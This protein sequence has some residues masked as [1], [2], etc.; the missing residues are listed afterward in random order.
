M[1][2]TR[3]VP[4]TARLALLG[5]LAVLSSCGTAPASYEGASDAGVTDAADSALDGATDAPDATED[6]GAV[7]AEPNDDAGPVPDSEPTP[8]AEPIPDAEPTPDTPTAPDVPES[9]AVDDTGGAD[10]PPWPE[11]EEACRSACET[12]EEGGMGGCPVGGS[13]GC[14]DW[15]LDVAPG[16]APDLEEAFF[17]CLAEDPL[18]FESVLQCA[19]SLAYPAPFPHVVT[20][21]GSGYDAWNGRTVRAGV[22]ERADELVRAETVVADGQFELEFDVVMWANQSH[23]T[24]FYIDADS[25]GACDGDVDETGTG[26]I[27]LWGFPEETIALPDWV[28]HVEHDPD[29]NASF[30]CSYL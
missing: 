17:Q 14:A 12:R 23:L 1:S 24:L 28:I 2:T 22:E 18:C 19:I 25:D 29:R 13:D 5:C 7:D 27:E 3:A 26:S 15:C 20:L 30:V 6:A 16:V 11:L 8:D 9:D 10:V 21:R 4:R